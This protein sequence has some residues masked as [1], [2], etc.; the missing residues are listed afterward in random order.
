MPRRLLI[1]EA[2]R[3]A[4]IALTQPVKQGFGEGQ[5]KAVIGILFKFDTMLF[6]S[7][8]LDLKDQLLLHAEVAVIDQVP[9][10]DTIDADQLISG[11]K[12]EC[13]PD[14]ACLDGGDDRRL[15]LT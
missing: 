14:R 13:L 2:E 8:I 3:T 5:P 1:D 7:S 12:P 4:V 9:G 11:L 15:R 10:T 6:S